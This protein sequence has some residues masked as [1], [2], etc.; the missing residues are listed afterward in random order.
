MST[1]QSH[2]GRSPELARSD[3]AYALICLSIALLPQLLTVSLATNY[4]RVS[5]GRA[6]LQEALKEAAKI[7]VIDVAAGK[8]YLANKVK[9]EY[10]ENVRGSFVQS[11]DGSVMCS[12]TGSVPTRIIGLISLPSSEIV[13][14]AFAAG[15]KPKH[16]SL[17]GTI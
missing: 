4:L 11:D 16:I 15:S 10:V 17:R 8:S 14:T 2:L 6:A 13:A 3:R 5:Q 12:A 9:P 1:D 7:A